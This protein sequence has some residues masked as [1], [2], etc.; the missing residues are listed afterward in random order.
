VQTL[1]EHFQINHDFMANEKVC[2]YANLSFEKPPGTQKDIEKLQGMEP[3]AQFLAKV[4]ARVSLMKEF[5][6]FSAKKSSYLYF[7]QG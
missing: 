2:D 6:L 1:G 7:S 4:E 3:W 5:L